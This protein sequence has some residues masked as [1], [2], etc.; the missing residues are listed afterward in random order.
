MGYINVYNPHWWLLHRE[1]HLQWMGHG[2]HEIF[3]KA[4]GTA[5]VHHVAQSCCRVQRRCA[6]QWQTA[7]NANPA[8]E[9]WDAIIIWSI[10]CKESK[11]D[12]HRCRLPMKSGEFHLSRNVRLLQS[13]Y[14]P[15]L[16]STPSSLDRKRKS[17][18]ETS[19]VP[20]PRL[21]G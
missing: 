6:L 19:Q 14:V 16:E 8:T 20:Y 11:P 7:C 5:E 4:I 9:S 3:T 15:K 2:V 21:I 12:L 10:H 18:T 1:N 17:T 13:A